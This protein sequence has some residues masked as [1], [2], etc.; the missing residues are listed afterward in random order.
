M[1]S[2][3]PYITYGIAVLLWI[4]LMAIFLEGF[5]NLRAPEMTKEPLPF[6]EALWN[7]WGV[8]VVIVALIIF[9]SGAGILVLLGGKWRWE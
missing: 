5:T 4:G 8:T 2:L 9:A 3:K 7:S 6:G 1:S